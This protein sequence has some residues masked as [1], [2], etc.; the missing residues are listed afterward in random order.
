MD[1][2]IRPMNEQDW[3]DVGKIYGQG[4][5]TGKATFQQEIPEYTNWDTS[6]LP[7]CRFVA[8]SNGKTVGWIALSGVSS[9]C[10]YRGVAEVSVY[11]ADT[12]RGRGVGQKLLRHIIAESEKAG[13]WMLQSGIMEDNPASLRLHEK[14][15]FRKVG[16]RERIGRD[17]AG[18]WRSTVLMEKRSATTGT[19]CAT[20]R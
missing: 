4:I 8:V 9:R 15:G 20:S 7:V 3:P 1:I 6:H 17:S 2:A 14:C 10:V 16:F 18:Q 11:I 13:I 19:A 5:A 12:A